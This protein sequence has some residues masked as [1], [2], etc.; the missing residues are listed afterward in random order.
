M[1]Q[2]M[3]RE[4]ERLQSLLNRT[5]EEM[6]AL[7]ADNQKLASRERENLSNLDRTEKTVINEINEECRRS[8]TVLGVSPRQVQFR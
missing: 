1:L 7:K 3:Q 5:E 4:T 2:E 8:A 6:R